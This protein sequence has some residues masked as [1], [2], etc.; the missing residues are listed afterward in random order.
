MAKN[1]HGNQSMTNK[2]AKYDRQ[3]NDGADPTPDNQIPK[4]PANNDEVSESVHC[5]DITI[6]PVDSELIRILSKYY[7][8]DPSIFPPEVVRLY[9]QQ[10]T[11]AHAAILAWR[12][13]QVREFAD[14]LKAYSHYIGHENRLVVTHDDIDFAIATLTPS[15]EDKHE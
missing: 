10:L 12:D 3:R 5:A 2:S 7:K 8:A 6:P 4:N 11:E 15:E 13:A 1:Q 14:Q 9:E